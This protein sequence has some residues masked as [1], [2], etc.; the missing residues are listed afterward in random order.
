MILRWLVS[1]WVRQTAEQQL[2][3]AVTGAMQGDRESDAD[4]ETEPLPPIDIAVLFALSVE[5]GG[6]V[7]L[8]QQRT[9]TH[10]ASHTEHRGTLN[11]KQILVVE[12]GVGQDAARQVV[13]DVISLHQPKWIVSAGFAGA[14]QPDL[15]RGHILMS[16]EVTDM[17]SEKLSIGL[18][19]DRASIDASPALHVGRLLTV[20]QLIRSRSQKEQLGTDHAA[21]ACD[22]ETFAIAQACQQLGT[23]FMSVR[24]ISDSIDDELPKE[25]EAL[26]AQKSVVGKL[27]AA[28]GAVFNRPS[29]IKDMWK[30]KED[31]L[32]ATD[33]L[34]KFLSGV[35]DQLPIA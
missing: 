31:A 6:F 3:G 2:R 22:M 11:G 1:N 26:L 30:L 17:A 4:S 8:V 13:K 15:R 23:K 16:D 5:S 18:T 28:A 27:G 32:K 10:C 14:L 12:S 19:V 9:T 20:D 7:D 29:S 25:I 21:L 34:A 24:I 35:I 33:R